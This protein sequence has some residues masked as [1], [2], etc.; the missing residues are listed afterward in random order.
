[1]SVWREMRTRNSMYVMYVEYLGM[2][3]KQEYT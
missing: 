1:M 3:K 2:K